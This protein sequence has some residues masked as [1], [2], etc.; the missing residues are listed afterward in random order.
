MAYSLAAQNSSSAAPP[1][2]IDGT[3]PPTGA[4][5]GS[6]SSSLSGLPIGTNASPIIPTS[7]TSY[8]PDDKYRL[9]VG[10]RISLQ[11]VEDRD[12]PK[13]LVIADS[14]ELDA[15]YVGRLA[16]SERTCKQLATELKALLEKEYYYRATV[17][18]AL[19]AANKFLGRIYVW[20]I[21]R[22]SCRERV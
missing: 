13:S 7:L 2:T 12:F 4:G 14:G 10:D 1:V 5:A 8:V 15:P 3:F 6:S 16:A 9:R 18:I 20:E 22:A 21:G 11:I 19:D 17:I